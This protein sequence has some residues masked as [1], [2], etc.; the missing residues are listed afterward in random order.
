M[1]SKAVCRGYV[2]IIFQIL[3]I[4]TSHVSLCGKQDED[5]NAG[6]G[7]RKSR[8]KTAALFAGKILHR[9]Q[10]NETGT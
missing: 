9:I 10:E 8:L 3:E 7:T 5:P 4:T 2:Y 1:T 6:L